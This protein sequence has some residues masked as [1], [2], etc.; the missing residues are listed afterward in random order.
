[1]TALLKDGTRVQPVASP[2]TET[3]AATLTRP[4]NTT[5]YT[6]NDAVTDTGGAACS[7]PNIANSVDAPVA[8]EALRIT[9]A[10]TGPGTAVATFEVYVYNSAPTPAADNAAFT[11]PI[12]G[13]C[14]RYSGTFMAATDGSV[15]TLTPAVGSRRILKPVAGDTKLYFIVKT[16]TAFTP[17]ANST[18][19]NVIAEAFQGV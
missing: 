17:S 6:A 8:L 3:A 15:A 19:F 1:M 14:G 4:A 12:A 7:W 13:Y 10:D 18:V 2:F 9:T 11:F 16:L 5:A